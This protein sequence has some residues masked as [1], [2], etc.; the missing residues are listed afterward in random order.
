MKKVKVTIT[1]RT[2]KEGGIKYLWF[3]YTCPYHGVDSCSYSLLSEV[4][5][6][7]L[8]AVKAE[9][10]RKFGVKAEDLATVELPDSE[11]DPSGSHKLFIADALPIKGG[12]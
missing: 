8:P 9:L 1:E 10:Y 2:S 12:S 5:A 11:L 4:G 6:V 7:Y 3:K